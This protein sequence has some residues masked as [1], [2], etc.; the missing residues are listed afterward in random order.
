MFLV[1]FGRNVKLGVK[2]LVVHKLR[3]LL[4][5]LGVV[6]GVA[7]VISMLAVGEGASAQA[8]ERIRLLGANNIIIESVKSA[9]Q[10]NTNQRVSIYGLLYDD[11]DRIAASFEHVT[12]V[13]P[14]KALKREGRLRTR[15]ADLRVVATTPDWFDL[16]D[17]RMILGRHLSQRD[18]D[19]KSNVVV[20]TQFGRDKLLAGEEI[21]GSDIV[22][23]GAPYEVVGVVDSVSGQ[24]GG[25]D[26]TPDEPTDAYIPLS[27]ARDRFGDLNVTRS[28]G[29][30]TREQVELHSILAEVDETANVEATAEAI[31]FLL[32]RF[33]PDGDYSITVPMSLI[34]QAEETQRTWDRVLGSIAGISLLVGGIGIMNIMLAS[35]TERTREIGIRRAIG[36]RKVQI[37][38]QF[39]IETVVL[40]T[41]GG[42][43]GIGLGF[44]I[45]AV[46]EARVENMPTEVPLSAVV[47]AA[48]IS[49]GV[50]VLFGIYPAAR[51]A[52]LDPIQALR[53]E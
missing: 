21:L 46:I 11:A 31:R 5:M 50:G 48:G 29:S 20:L 23:G 53:H 3:S 16:V 34:R 26:N 10:Q 4:T 45:P 44:A 37:V 13:A 33:H 9:A 49:V 25:A 17:R 24:D 42:L 14:V 8:Q 52:N 32:E 35:V 39:L 27:L 47:L 36:A 6:F 41:I 40:S 30:F 2:T 38:G 7:S 43:I 15:T 18:L 19:A 12:K 51:A 1:R 22:I 28:S